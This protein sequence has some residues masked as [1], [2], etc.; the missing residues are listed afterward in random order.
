MDCKYSWLI[1]NKINLYP[2]FLNKRKGGISMSLNRG[3]L[4]EIKIFN[5]LKKNN[6]IPQHI[7]KVEEIEGQ[8]IT[9]FNRSGESGIEVKLSLNSAFGSGTLKFDYNN[10]KSPWYLL[11]TDIDDEND[12]VVPKNI[13]SKIAKK[14][15]L[16]EKVNKHWYT[17]N[18]NYFPLYLEETNTKPIKNITLIPKGKRGKQD[19]EV[20]HEFKINCSK[21][22]IVDYYTS[23]GSYYVQ[24][25]GKGLYWFGKSDPLNISKIISKFNPTNTFIRV[26]VQS[27]GSGKYNFSYGLYCKNLP[28]SSFDL[29]KNTNPSWL[30]PSGNP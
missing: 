30:G 14:Y 6:N 10:K 3:Q 12:E 13:I 21:D 5:E 23:K 11:E 25:G 16:A 8:D 26:R 29:E 9:V 22:D 28:N 15:K 27:K 20:L 1:L 24:I 7:T 4:Y 19:F 17:D 18:G 2:L